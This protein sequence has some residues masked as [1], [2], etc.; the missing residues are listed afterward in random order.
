MERF[1]E[2]QNIAHYED[3]LKTETDP[4]KRAMLQ[5]L[6]TEE[7]AKQTSHV[8]LKKVALL[9]GLRNIHQLKIRR[10]LAS[11]ANDPFYLSMPVTE[12]KVQGIVHRRRAG[13]DYEHLRNPLLAHSKLI[14]RQNAVRRRVGE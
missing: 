4:I 5:R 7:K 1:I 2:R 11:Q 12:L 10:S 13:R 8:K 3:Q 14:D 9:V 6:T